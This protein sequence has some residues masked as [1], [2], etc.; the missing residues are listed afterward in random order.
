MKVALCNRWQLPVRFVASVRSVV[1]ATEWEV[2]NLMRVNDTVEATYEERGVRDTIQRLAGRGGD[3]LARW[4]VPV[5]RVSLGLVFLVFGVLKFFPGVSPAE[6]L[7]VQTLESLTL[8]ALSGSAALLVTAIVETFIGITLITGRLLRTG[9]A[10]LAVSMVGIMSPL[11]LSFDE[12]LGNGPTLT[13]Q[14]VFK[15][16]VLIAAALVVGA[17]VLNSRRLG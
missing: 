8:G 9:L 17:R 13:A 15:D 10:V 14:Y 6:G 11:A 2:N 7:A 16:I 5:L 4:S 1:D 3:M 12:L